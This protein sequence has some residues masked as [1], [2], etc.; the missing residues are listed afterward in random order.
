MGI[1]SLPGGAGIL[2]RDTAGFR[3]FLQET[4]LIDDQYAARFIPEICRDELPQ[5][6]SHTL[7]IPARGIQ[8]TLHPLRV[9]L[10]DCLRELPAVL[11]FYPAKQPTQIGSD[12]LAYFRPGEA[13]GD[14]PLQIREDARP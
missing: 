10:P 11:A 13:A 1:H 6:I 2:A 7:G 8:K 9:C 4:G 14:A 5:I 12:P 3:P